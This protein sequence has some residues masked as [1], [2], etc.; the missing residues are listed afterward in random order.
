MYDEYLE[1]IYRC[2]L[3]D[4]YNK[5]TRIRISYGEIICVYEKAY[6]IVV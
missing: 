5:L 1:L 4:I 6:M 3:D 2:M